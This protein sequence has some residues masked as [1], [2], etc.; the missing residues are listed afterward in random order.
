MENEKQPLDH[1][2]NDEITE[3]REKWEMY[4]VGHGIWQKTEIMENEKQPFD[5]LKNDEI[6]E[7]H[8]KW[9][10]HYVGLWPECGKKT[11]NHDKWEIHTLG[12]E[13]WR[14]KLKKVEN[15]EMSPVGRGIC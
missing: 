9:E 6:T 3:K 8:E 5:D 11:E 1:L 15:L 14:G 12:R 13:I 7:K 10:M 2:K 4:T